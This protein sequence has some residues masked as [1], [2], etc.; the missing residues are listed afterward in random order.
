MCTYTLYTSIFVVLYV[1]FRRWYNNVLGISFAFT[2]QLPIY[3][4]TI[5]FFLLIMSNIRISLSLGNTIIFFNLLT[6]LFSHA[7]SISVDSFAHVHLPF[8][9]IPELSLPVH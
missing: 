9:H 1:Q 5:F 2:I 8:L 3:Q 4:N 6:L 7:K